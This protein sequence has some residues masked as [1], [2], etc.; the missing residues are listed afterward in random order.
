[1][2]E[3]KGHRFLLGL[4]GMP[5]SGKSTARSILENLGCYALDADRLAHEVL[6]LP[7]TV[8]KLLE[9]FGPEVMHQGK[10][11]RSRIAEKVF[12]DKDKLTRLNNIVHPEVRRLAR[13]RI[14][15]FPDNSIVVYDVPL[16][17]ET[18]LQKELDATLVIESS[19]EIRK[20]RV[21]QRGWSEEQ[22]RERDQHH[23]QEKALLADYVVR[24]DGS[25][26]E[27]EEQLKE[28]IKQIQ[29]GTEQ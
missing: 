22:L 20:H 26:Q 15:G 3:N 29:S 27:L 16:L 18:N 19:F 1:M 17:F 6:E 14:L 28:V 24:N 10:P 21:S 4:T 2:L 9:L 25:L 11:E 23:N 5:G 8:E 12:K 13:E 7:Q